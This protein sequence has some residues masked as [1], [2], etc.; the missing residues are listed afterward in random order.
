[1]SHRSS[2][3]AEVAAK[4]DTYR[5]ESMGMWLASMEPDR[6]IEMVEDM[7]ALETADAVAPNKRR[8]D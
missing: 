7:S 8:E 2:L 4:W 5:L 6:L 1:M 3:T